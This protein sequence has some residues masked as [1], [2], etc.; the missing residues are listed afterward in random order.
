MDGSN[1]STTFTDSSSNALTV[2]ANGNAQIST[3]RSQFGTGS[4]GLFDGS[5]DYLSVTLSAFGT[6][7]FTIE[8]GAYL[9]SLPSSNS[10]RNFFDNRAND[11]DGAGFVWGV[12]SSGA[13]YL[14]TS[15]GFR[16]TTGS[17]S[18]NAWQSVALTRVSG[19]WRMFIDG[20][21]QTGSYTSA[22]DLSRTAARIGMDWATLYGW[23]G[24]FDNYRIT[25]GVGRYSSNYSAP[26]APFP[27]A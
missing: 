23:H 2:T 17:I 1:G 22:A 15:G 11:L 13:M 9:A 25:N 14:F 20:V 19:V 21:L 7:D 18:L 4:S 26:T 16:L 3:A 27:D 8:T 10:Y 24:N 12:N 6:S 5:G